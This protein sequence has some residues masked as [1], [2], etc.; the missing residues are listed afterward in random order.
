MHTCK[1]LTAAVFTALEQICHDT[2]KGLTT[3]RHNIPPV[4]KRNGKTG[5]GDLVIKD[6]DLGLRGSETMTVGI[7]SS[8]PSSRTKS[9]EIVF[10]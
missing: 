6:A 8:T 1:K 2:D 4:E 7:S 10:A 3:M 9:V 5:R